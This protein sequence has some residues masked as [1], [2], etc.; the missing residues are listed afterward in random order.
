MISDT[1]A[2]QGANDV[3]RTL[4]TRQWSDLY[5]VDRLPVALSGT[6]TH[7]GD[8]LQELRAQALGVR[9]V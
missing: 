2:V 8:N 9:P 4:D 3:V 5:T 1:D 6:D 7:I